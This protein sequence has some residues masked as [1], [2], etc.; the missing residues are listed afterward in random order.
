MSQQ[1]GRHER[2]IAMTA[3]SHPVS[4]THAE[5][6]QFFNRS[7]G[8]QP[9]LVDKIVIGLPRGI[10]SHTGISALFSTAYPWVT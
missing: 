9:E 2:A 5:T 10:R 6:D 4:V 8:I 1:V 7:L 3:D